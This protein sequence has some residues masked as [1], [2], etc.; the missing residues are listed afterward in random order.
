MDFLDKISKISGLQSGNRKFYSTETA[1]LHYTDHLLQ[2]MDENEYLLLYYL[3]CLKL[4]T[5][6]NTKTYYRGCTYWV[7]LTPL[8]PGLRAT[9][10]YASKWSGSAVSYPTPPT[11][12]RS[13]IG[14]HSRSSFVHVVRQQPPLCSEE[15]RSSGL[16][17]RHQAAFPDLNSVSQ[18]MQKLSLPHVVLLGKNIK[19]S[20]VVKDLE[21]WIDSALTFDDH[22]SKLSSSCLYNLRRINRIKHLL[23]NKTLVLIINTLIFSRLFYCSTVW[24]YTSSKNISKL[25]LIQNFACRIILGIKKICSCLCYAPI[26]WLARRP[27]K[28]SIK[29][30][31]DGL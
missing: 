18:P 31:Y 9:Y 16:C 3:T 1:R 19:S 26:P 20:P 17:R 6:S 14:V 15:V 5:A 27:S 7:C 4:S 10:H 25:Q 11:D 24:G 2:N 23:D 22:V 28:T 30:L 8:W 21:V 12:S 29:Y 13:G